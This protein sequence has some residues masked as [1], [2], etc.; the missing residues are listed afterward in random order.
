DVIPQVAITAAGPTAYC[1]GSSVT[2]NA[3]TDPSYTNYAWTPGGPSGPSATSFTVGGPTNSTTVYRV[4]ATGAGGC[5]SHQDIP[6]HVHDTISPT[7]TIIGNQ[8]LCSGQTS[9]DLQGDIFGATGPAQ[10]YAWSTSETTQLITVFSG[11][12]Y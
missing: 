3:S 11:A 4:T 6:V 12:T 2:L 9:S 1:P 7:I 8:N 5:T 10:S